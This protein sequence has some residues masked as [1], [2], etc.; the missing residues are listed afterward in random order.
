MLG[1]VLGES[2]TRQADNRFRLALSVRT[3]GDTTKMYTSIYLHTVCISLHEQPR[4]EDI[5]WVFGAV[6]AKVSNGHEFWD[7]L[8]VF[9]ASTASLFSELESS[10]IF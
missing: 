5:W 6:L 10:G 3:A 1:G 4:N 7:S 2:S 9:T 8:I